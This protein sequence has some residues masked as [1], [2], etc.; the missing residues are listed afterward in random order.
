MKTH[1]LPHF[2]SIKH[3]NLETIFQLFSTADKFRLF[4]QEAR[5]H[6]GRILGSFFY[7]PSTRTRLSFASAAYRLDAQVL[8]FDDPH[9]ASVAKGESLID[10]IRVVERYCD[11]IVLRHPHDGAAT[12]ASMV[13]RVPI[14]NAGDGSHEHPTQTLYDLYTI[15]QEWKT[16]QGRVVG[17]MGDLRYGRTIHSLALA[18]AQFGA[19]LVCIAPDTLQMPSHLLQNLQTVT[20]VQTVNRLENVIDSLEV[21]YIIR[22]QKE[23]FDPEDQESNLQNYSL[24]REHLAHARKD[25]LILHPL[26]RNEEIPYVIDE[27][28]RARYFDQVANGVFMRMA[29]LDH[30]FQ[31]LSTLPAD[32]LV[33][34]SGFDAPWKNDAP[35]KWP[36]CNNM[37]CIT[38]HEREIA[39]RY[40]VTSQALLRCT[41]CDHEQSTQ[42]L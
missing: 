39:P 29:L 6:Q 30:I 25:L 17:L 41:Y 33:A 14:I 32:A 19:T 4:P 16:L 20:Q 18:L 36:P 2:I 12:L 26:P 35:Q 42:L 22:P 8:G 5:R 37:R 3:I 21:L 31:Q 9:M 1:L 23:R 24:S 7:E 15:W 11:A 34:S 27:D 10:T 38:R 13:A 40:E 28:Y